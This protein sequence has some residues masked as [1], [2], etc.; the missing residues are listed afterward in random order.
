MFFSYLVEAEALAD[1]ALVV[2]PEAGGTV[3]A[4]R[5]SA[6]EVPLLVRGHLGVVLP[7]V[8]NVLE[9]EEKF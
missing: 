6:A 2:V 4:V 9:K 5:G 3:F 1:A 7:R 8:A